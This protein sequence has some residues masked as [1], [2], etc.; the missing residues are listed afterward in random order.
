MLHYM[1]LLVI[2]LSRGR[3][4]DVRELSPI[5]T[6]PRLRAASVTIGIELSRWCPGQ[7]ERQRVHAVLHAAI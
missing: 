7:T 5:Y 6:R 3:R 1:I 4:R 2:L